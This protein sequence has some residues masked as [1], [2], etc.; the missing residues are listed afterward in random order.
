MQVILVKT[1]L[2][3][4]YEWKLDDQYSLDGNLSELQTPKFEHLPSRW[5][6]MRLSFGA[7]IELNQF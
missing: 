1:N 4:K 6:K 2:W 3:V 7:R 5:L